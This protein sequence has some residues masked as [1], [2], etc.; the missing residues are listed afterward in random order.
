MMTFSLNL[1]KC[2][3]SSLFALLLTVPVHA[4]IKPA[5]PQILGQ[6]EG[7]KDRS[8]RTLIEEWKSK[9]GRRAIPTLLGIA[10][11][12]KKR[13]QTRYIALMGAARLSGPEIFKTVPNLLKDKSWMIR[14]G[15]L[16]I[17]RGMGSSD[18][19]KL[20]YPLL[21]DPAWVVR[22]E[23]IE[24]LER[25]QPKGFD[26]QLVAVL[27]DATNIVNGK[28]QL[29]SY[30][31]LDALAH[32]RKSLEMRKRVENSSAAKKDAQFRAAIAAKF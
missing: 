32:T 19:A 6:I 3:I 15:G 12:A 27:D 5:A 14:S 17:I 25:R 4:A 20:A 30:R 9:H 31:A 28:A 10:Q 24:L 29:I 16:R 21:K 22:A 26:D 13:D 7:W 1:K 2:S 8:F 11:D 23:A 18:Q